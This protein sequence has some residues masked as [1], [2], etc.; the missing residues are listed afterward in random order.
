M[1]RWQNLKN[2]IGNFKRILRTKRV[3]MLVYSSFFILFFTTLSI[4]IHAGLYLLAV[5]LLILAIFTAKYGS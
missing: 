3:D 1:M 5:L 4:N 2:R